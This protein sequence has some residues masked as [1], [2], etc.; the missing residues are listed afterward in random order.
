ME[1]EKKKKIRI[2]IAIVSILAIVGAV[3]IFF[4]VAEKGYNKEHV[5]LEEQMKE[6]RKKR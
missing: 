5:S 1:N 3:I 2:V 6:L 4:Q